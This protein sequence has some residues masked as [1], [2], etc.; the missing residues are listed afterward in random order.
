MSLN[1][2]ICVGLWAKVTY[3]RILVSL[4]VKNENKIKIIVQIFLHILLVS[5]VVIE[6]RQLCGGMTIVSKII[7]NAFWTVKNSYTLVVKSLILV[8]EFALNQLVNFS[9]D[10]IH[11]L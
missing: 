11:N 2:I 1:V 8:V 7:D 6:H 9:F 10:S 3:E 5:I 4:S